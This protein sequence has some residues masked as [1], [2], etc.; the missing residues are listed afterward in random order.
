MLKTILVPL[1]GADGGETVFG[2]AF[3]VGR[4]FDAH[5]EVLLVRRNPADAL[6]YLTRGLSVTAAMKDQ[7]VQAATQ[8]ADAAA[9]KVRSE[10]DAYCAA[11]QIPVGVEP[12]GPGTVSAAWREE[13][14]REGAGIVARRG[15]LA[16][17]IVLPQPAA[18]APAPAVLEAALMRTSKPVLVVPPVTRDSFGQTIGIGW[19]GSAEAAS[20]VAGA[21]PFLQLAEKIRVFMTDEDARPQATAADLVHYLAWQGIAASTHKFDP[22]SRS[23]GKALLAEAE[24]CR[25]DLLV[26]GGYGHSRTRELI[27]GG[28]TRQVLATGKI[29]VLMAH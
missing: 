18:E 15:R 16:D 27:L 19:D 12:P 4:R 8:A 2:P 21:M 26:L 7:V 5:V 20:A 22:G 1:D 14:G 11:N 3:S 28:V 17:L 9:A 13:V 24:T 10:F 25:T 6:R 29:P 23:V